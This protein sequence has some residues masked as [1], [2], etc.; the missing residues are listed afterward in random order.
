MTA[1]IFE[2]DPEK[3]KKRD[4]K[5]KVGA[6]GGKASAQSD[7]L[8]RPGV[9]KELSPEARQILEEGAW[10]MNKIQGLGQETNE[11][12]NKGSSGL[13][14]AAKD[15]GGSRKEQT[16]EN[17][18]VLDMQNLSS[19]V[20]EK[21][22]NRWRKQQEDREQKERLKIWKHVDAQPLG[23]KEF[24]DHIPSEE[25]RRLLEET[26]VEEGEFSE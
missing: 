4:N 8:N 25:K 23:I 17:K 24:E 14:E 1:E 10:Q 11:E 6:G 22:W 5:P 18:K 7:F 9:P 20:K 15:E 21:Q 3:R 26:G 2:F 16:S 19:K 12:T 13:E